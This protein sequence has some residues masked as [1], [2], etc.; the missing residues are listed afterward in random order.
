[1]AKVDLTTGNLDTTFTQSTGADL[2][3]YALAISGSSL[4]LGGDFTTYRGSTAQRLAKVD[5]TTGNLDTTFTQSSG[6]NNTVRTLAIS[7]SSLYV[8]GLFTT[9]RA[10]NGYYFIPIDLTHGEL[11]EPTPDTPSGSQSTMTASGPV[12]ANGLATSTITLNLKKYDG[13]PVSNI[14]PTIAISGSNNI[15]NPC[16]MTNGSGTSTCTFASTSDEFKTITLTSPIGLAKTVCFYPTAAQ[17]AVDNTAS[18]NSGAANANPFTWSHTVGTGNN[19]ILVVSTANP[20]TSVAVSS[21]TYGGTA[22]TRL[23]QNLSAGASTEIWYLLNPPSGTATVSVSLASSAKFAGGSVSYR[24]VHQTTPFGT[25]V[26]ATGSGGAISLLVSNTRPV[27]WIIDSVAIQTSNTLTPTSPQTQRW[28][29]GSTG[30]GPSTGKVTSAGS[31]LPGTACG[32][33]SLSWTAANNAP[34]ATIGVILRPSAQ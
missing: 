12:L 1:L 4:F 14:V 29:N 5:L 34:W 24:N 33:V 20:G 3:V 26:A 23:S 7:G 11:S 9:Y 28:H 27:D 30:S 21:V 17:L 16:S 8:E 31:T 19:R 18:M 6:V 13:T 15:Q 25:P 10:S 22:L 32:D 2:T